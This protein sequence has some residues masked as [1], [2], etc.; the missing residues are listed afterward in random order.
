MLCS[1]VLF[2][3]V[4]EGHCKFILRKED[5]R[6]GVWYQHLEFK[7]NH[8]HGLCLVRLEFH[9]NVESDLLLIL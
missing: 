9:I 6:N 8:P 2:S 4:D 7:K 5:E 3:G 1:D